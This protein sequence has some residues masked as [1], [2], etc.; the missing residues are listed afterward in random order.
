MPENGPR[1]TRI[2]FAIALIEIARTAATI[3]ISAL[4][5][6]GEGYRPTISINL[7][8]WGAVVVLFVLAQVFREGTRLREEEKMTI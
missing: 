7:A 8:L 2:A 5:D 1:L 6:V 4:V 3:I